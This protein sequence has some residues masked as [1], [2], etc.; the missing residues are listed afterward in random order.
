[1]NHVFLMPAGGHQP[2]DAADL[3]HLHDGSAHHH[4]PAPPG[5]RQ[6]G[7]EDHQGHHLLQGLPAE[8]AGVRLPQG[9]G[10]AHSRR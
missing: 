2:R 7:G 3:P 10:N 5:R 8:H 1:M 9:G 6:H 4:G